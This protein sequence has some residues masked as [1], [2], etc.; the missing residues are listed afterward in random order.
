MPG[1]ETAPALALVI[2]TPYSSLESLRAL[3]TQPALELTKAGQLGSAAV[4]LASISQVRV[5]MGADP[6]FEVTVTLDFYDVWYR[7]PEETFTVPLDAAAKTAPVFPG[8]SGKVTD[9]LVRLTD[10]TSP[11]VRDNA[12]SF[13]SYTGTI[14]AGSWLR[15]DA[16]TG[17]AW[18]TNTDAWTGGTEVDA[19][20]LGFGSR[21]GFL[22]ITPEFT[23]T[24]ATRRGKLTVTTT[25]RGD[26]AAI[27]IRGHNA[28]TS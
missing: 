21:P 10:C 7:G 17:R 13:F 23:L 5:G 9:T 22:R 26:T 25:A 16:V 1:R 24:P 20:L 14:P 6:A 2:G 28:Y 3:L 11:K 8:L 12:G 19:L 4:Q 18:L 27:D 15:F